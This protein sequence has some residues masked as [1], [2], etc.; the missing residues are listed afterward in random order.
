M[1]RKQEL[2]A[3]FWCEENNSVKVID[4]RL[5]PYEYRY[6]EIN[7]V[8]A[9]AEAISSMLLR[10]APLIGI[11]AAYGMALAAQ[12]TQDLALAD[13]L[14]R[15]TRPTAVNLN[16]ALDEIQSVIRTQGASHILSHAKW[17]HADDIERC[18]Q[19]SELGASY[20]QNKFQAKTQSGRGLRV[21]T[22]CNAGALATGGYGTALG[23][24][25]S[26]HSRALIDRVFVNETRPR[27]QGARLTAWEL[28]YEKI[29]ATLICDNMAAHI[30][31]SENIDLIITGAD[32]IA[33][34]GDTAN[35]IGT[36]ALAII[37]KHQG[38][39]FYV[40]APMSTFDMSIQ[41]ASGIIIEERNPEEVLYINGGICSTDSKLLS[42]RNPAFDVTDNKLIGEIFTEEGLYKF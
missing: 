32:R 4:Q 34:N 18:K 28:V 30:M 31:R 15:K 37:A 23:V 20:I 35:K 19:I 12:S 27:Q 8:E 39:P 3:I 7:S 16:W 9:M 6:V 1:N 22:H 21:M 2:K 10:G 42:V 33:R 29:P 24:I 5:L 17:I 40:A 11:A 38:I 25:R 36:Y 14:L 26:L 41:D 13:A